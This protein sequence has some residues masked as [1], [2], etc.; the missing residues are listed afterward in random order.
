MK[1][2]VVKLGEK[3]KESAEVE[4]Y[5]RTSKRGFD[6]YTI[7]IYIHESSGLRILKQRVYETVHKGFMCLACGKAELSSVA[8]GHII[9]EQPDKG[10]CGMCASTEEIFNKFIDYD[11]SGEYKLKA[12]A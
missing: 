4:V 9:V 6:L 10:L 8:N 1:E 7:G 11:K 12:Q 3:S 5:M 2:L